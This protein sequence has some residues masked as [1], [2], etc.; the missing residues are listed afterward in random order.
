[1]T[2]VAREE[3]SAEAIL[4]AF[5]PTYLTCPTTYFLHILCA[6]SKTADRVGSPDVCVISI[7]LHFWFYFLS[8]LSSSFSGGDAVKTGGEVPPWALSGGVTV[9]AF[10]LVGRVTLVGLPFE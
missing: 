2:A 1:M 5:M 8:C 4:P 3:P 10:R 6:L 9:V 7:T